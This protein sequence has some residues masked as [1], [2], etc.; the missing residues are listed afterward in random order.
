MTGRKAKIVCCDKANQTE[1][2]DTR[3]KAW[4]IECPEHGRTTSCYLC[5]NSAYTTERCSCHLQ[6]CSDLQGISVNDNKL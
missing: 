5:D 3:D 1:F 2:G 6:L 4:V